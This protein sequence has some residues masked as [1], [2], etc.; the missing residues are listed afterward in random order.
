MSMSLT[1][2]SSR[3]LVYCSSDKKSYVID[4]YEKQA[5]F[6]MKGSKGKYDFVMKDG[7]KNTLQR[8]LRRLN[9]ANKFYFSSRFNLSEI[10]L[11]SAQ[12]ENLMVE[13]Y[14]RD[15][16][17]EDEMN[18]YTFVDDGLVPL[19]KNHNGHMGMAEDEPNIYQAFKKLAA[20]KEE[21]AKHLQGEEK[22]V[23]SK[24]AEMY[25]R[26]AGILKS[27]F[28]E[29]QGTVSGV[30]EYHKRLEE[31]N[32]PGLADGKSAGVVKNFLDKAR[33]E[34]NDSLDKMV[35]PSESAEEKRRRLEIWERERLFQEIRGDF[36]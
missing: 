25:S 23:M 11:E 5:R 27:I 15:I 20:E 18:E 2:A 14:N 34:I 3:H 36:S 17:S 13:L 12:A 6:A 33:D 1:S 32:P 24:K 4:D 31:L 21:K 10:S 16:I 9:P 30:A 7:T 26:L 35:T 22:E 29:V 28:G 19:P 8:A